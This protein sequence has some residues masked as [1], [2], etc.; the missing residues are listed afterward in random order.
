[1]LA[2]ATAAIGK[3]EVAAAMVPSTGWFL[4]GFVRKEALVSSQIEGTQSSLSDLLLF[5]ME[6]APGVPF[7]DVVEVSN[8]VAALEHGMA[9]LR[10]GFPLSNRLLR[11]SGPC[12]LSANMVSCTATSTTTAPSSVSNALQAWNT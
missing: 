9:R 3:L 10:G 6:E 2:D 12:V 1:M 5:E 8:Y 4:Y 7:D 11:E